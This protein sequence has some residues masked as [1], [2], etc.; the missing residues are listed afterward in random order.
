M[1]TCIQSEKSII[2]LYICVT[3]AYKRLSENE[4]KTKD[5]RSHGKRPKLEASFNP[6]AH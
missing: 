4:R 3:N 5:R 1:L 6:I 2:Y